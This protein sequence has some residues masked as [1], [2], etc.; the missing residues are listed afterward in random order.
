[1]FS[2]FPGFTDFSYQYGTKLKYAAITVDTTI[3]GEKLRYPDGLKI[4][5]AWEDWFNEQ[6]RM[7][8]DVVAATEISDKL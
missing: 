6:V 7:P 5:K 4:R 8:S 1:M 2:V 3:D